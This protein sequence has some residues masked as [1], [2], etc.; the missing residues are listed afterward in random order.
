MI[1]IYIMA[2]F[3]LAVSTRVRTTSGYPQ[4]LT[5]GSFRFKMTTRIQVAVLVM[6]RNVCKE[7]LPQTLGRNDLLAFSE[8]SPSQRTKG[9]RASN[10]Q[11]FSILLL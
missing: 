4:Q 5:L 10:R 2:R 8:E 9:Y 7:H 3:H 6:W 1:C 11:V